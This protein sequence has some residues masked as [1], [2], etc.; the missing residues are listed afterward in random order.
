MTKHFIVILFYH[1]LDR[2][3][4]DYTDALGHLQI[5]S[6][7]NNNGYVP[8]VDYTRDYSPPPSQ[9]QRNYNTINSTGNYSTQLGLANNT[10]VTTT[11]SS[12]PTSQSSQQLQLNGQLPGGNLSLTRNRQQEL[13]QDN[14]LPSI[15]SSMNSLPNVLLGKV[16]A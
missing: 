9:L 2:Y 12:P 16:F 5:K 3:S 1:I 4:G 10:T 14:G 11:M 13:R 8:Y 6:G 15:Q 7:Q